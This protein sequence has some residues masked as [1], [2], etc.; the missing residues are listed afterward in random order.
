MSK[1]DK[2]ETPEG[3]KIQ[4]V[5]AKKM[6]AEGSAVKDA[7]REQFMASNKRDNRSQLISRVGAESAK[8][9]R[10]RLH[11]NRKAGSY[12]TVDG[13]V[14]VQSAGIA[15]SGKGGRS[16]ETEGEAVR[17]GTSNVERIAR[18]MAADGQRRSLQDFTD[19]NTKTQG[20]IDVG[21]AGVSAYAYSKDGNKKVNAPEVAGEVSVYSQQSASNTFA[22]DMAS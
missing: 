1:P 12:K 7:N 10:D 19:K 2:P 15:A 14:D 4:V 21:L 6:F 13:A 22:G 8:V 9:S 16:Y 5:L 18:S 17:M 3:E 11:A 20:M